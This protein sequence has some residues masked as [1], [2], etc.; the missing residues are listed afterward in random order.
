MIGGRKSYMLNL[1]DPPFPPTVWFL[2]NLKNLRLFQTWLQSLLKQGGHH[3]LSICSCFGPSTSLALVLHPASGTPSVNQVE[4]PHYLQSKTTEAPELVVG[5]DLWRGYLIMNVQ[6]HWHPIKTPSWPYAAVLLLAFD[7]E[8][9]ATR[10]IW[11]THREWLAFN[12][13][14][15]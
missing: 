3:C 5:P 2:K 4:D 15:P 13:V 12:K 8:E 9:A 11:R 14:L 1:R 6:D 10:K 7:L